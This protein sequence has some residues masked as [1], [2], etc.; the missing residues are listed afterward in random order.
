LPPRVQ[1]RD[2]APPEALRPAPVQSDTFEQAPQPTANSNTER[3]AAALGYFGAGVS[4]Y[5]NDPRRKKALEEQHLAEYESW[6]QART[7]TEQLDAIRSG[8]APYWSDPFIKEVVRRDYAALEAD[9]LAGE[10]D[11]ELTGGAIAK[12]G[13]PSFDPDAHVTEKARAYVERMGGDASTLS[14]FGK[15]LDSLKR[16]FKEKHQEALGQAQTAAIDNAARSR[17]DAALT[18]GFDADLGGGALAD[19]LMPIYQQF[20]PRAKGGSLD[21]KYGRIDD[22]V[23]EVLERKAA[24]PRYAAEARDMLT[25][26]R[27]GLDGSTRIGSL[28][29]VARNADK[30]VAIQR[31]ALKTLG[32]E[33]EA[34]TKAET[35]QKDVAALE[36][37][38]MSFAAI[39]DLDIVNPRD[40]SRA[41]KIAAKARQDAAVR[42]FLDATRAANGG[43][44]NFDAEMDVMLKN[45]IAHP[46]WVPQLLS[47][48]SGIANTN[49]TAGAGPE[50][51]Q[52]LQQ[53]AELYEKIA[54]RNWTY[55]RRHLPEDARQFYETYS[56][57]TKRMGLNPTQAAIATANA[58][59]SELRARNP[60]LDAENRA[61][62]EREVKGLDF[63]WSPFSG[64][65]GLR[66]DMQR[67]VID[68][69]TTLMRATPMDATKAI[70][71]ASARVQSSAVFVNGAAILSP[72]VLPGDDAHIQKLLETQF[73]NETPADKARI[74]RFKD[75]G[76]ESASDLTL[77]ERAGSFDVLNTNTGMPVTVPVLNNKGEVVG[78]RG[79]QIK[80]SDIAQVREMTNRRT[81]AMALREASRANVAERKRLERQRAFEGWV[82]STIFD[83]WTI[84]DLR[85]EETQA[86]A[87]R[88]KDAEERT[89][90]DVQAAT[91][92]MQRTHRGNQLK[93]PKDGR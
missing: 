31:V 7:S 76:V 14:A 8:K 90:R 16:S 67:E 73:K 85:P 39:K 55:A 57:L 82:K 52:A 59:S 71:A 43:K 11:E 61:K 89:T 83:P 28:A 62:V 33:A 25:A 64:T 26:E 45:G 15:Q 65:L 36:A 10:L 40:G 12:F 30:V 92:E 81:K 6:R 32:D 63:S 74:A 1:V 53:S 68:L 88:A 23:L 20:G 84:T 18:A 13:Q 49:V 80:P 37:N 77:R 2:L 58:F 3:L 79:V 9:R 48:H 87:K 34:N 47:A 51:L 29:D 27:V 46:E 24:D 56:T 93:R 21:L 60:N 41:I 69:A 91:D 86:A 75:W 42:S 70:E 44:P 54:G 35:L 38:D 22:L 66:G 19:A 4:D 50:Q 78:I 17:I 72:H 5:L